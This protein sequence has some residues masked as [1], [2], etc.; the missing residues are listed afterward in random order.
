MYK[1]VFLIKERYGLVLRRRLRQ[2]EG[3][4]QEWISHGVGEVHIFLAGY[5]FNEQIDLQQT[6]GY[7]FSHLKLFFACHHY[8]LVLH[9]EWF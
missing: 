3:E 8:E 4:S 2:I 9:L 1:I 5:F 7:G 6:K